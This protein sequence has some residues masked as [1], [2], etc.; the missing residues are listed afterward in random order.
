MATST[1]NSNLHPAEFGSSMHTFF[2]LLVGSLW[3]PLSAGWL[4][5]TANGGKASGSEMQTK[6]F[7]VLEPFIFRAPLSAGWLERPANGGKV[8]GSEK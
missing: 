3:A 7:F 6:L 4:E 8:S 1:V 5:R 2:I